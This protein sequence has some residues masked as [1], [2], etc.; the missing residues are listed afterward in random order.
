MG[1]LISNKLRRNKGEKKAIG[2]ALGLLSVGINVVNG[3]IA[4]KK[5]NDTA[6]DSIAL[7]DNLNNFE[8]QPIENPYSGSS[9]FQF[10][11]LSGEFTNPYANLKVA[12]QAAEF[13]A[14]QTDQA[15]ANTL[16]TLRSGG[17]G[18]GGATALAQA[19]AKS[20]QGISASIEQQE[21]QNQKLRAQ[22]EQALQQQIVAEKSRVES[23]Q[24]AENARVQGQ[25]GKGKA[26][27][28]NAQETRDNTELDRMQGL[29]DN[30]RAQEQQYRSDAMSS[31]TGAATGLLGVAGG[32]FGKIGGGGGG[33]G[34]GAGGGMGSSGGFQSQFFSGP[35][36]TSSD[37]RLKKNISKIG[38]STSGLNIY[39][40]DYINKEGTYQG[41]MSNEVP[42]EAVLVSDDGYDMV[43]YSKVD[44]DFKRIK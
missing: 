43:D 34:G 2:V 7:L 20:K 26:M 30:N 32:Q 38:K 25:I 14:Q 37:R 9:A 10:E 1:H 44:V 42:K 35:Q 40:F 21:T 3:V 5:A 16:D 4:N 11:D 22:G 27:M 15:L 36:F 18:A 13:E 6:N 24:S 41:V 12:T 29:Y 28:F 8:R 17:M 39:E 31:F 33:A 19:A 23:M